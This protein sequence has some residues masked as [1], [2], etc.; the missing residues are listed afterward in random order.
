[1]EII[2]TL[3]YL[4]E[5]CKFEINS[6]AKPRSPKLLGSCALPGFFTSGLCL[7]ETLAFVGCMGAGLAVVNIANPSNPTVIDSYPAWRT[8]GIAIKDTMAYLATDSLRVVNVADPRAAHQICCFPGLAY[9]ADVAVNGSRAYTSSDPDGRF[10]VFDISNPAHPTEVGYHDAPGR[11]VKIRQ[12]GAFVYAACSG[13]G[14]CIFDTLVSVGI[15]AARGSPA[16]PCR[17]RV[18]PNPVHNFGSIVLPQGTQ[19]PSQVS[20]WAVSGRLLA[21]AA[22]NPSN[23]GVKRWPI[24]FTPFPPGVYVVTMQTK[25]GQMTAK[26]VKR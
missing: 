8:W 21:R 25:A 9:P 23:Q 6:I 17:L 11:V 20:I 16:F 2:D 22:I 10:Y 26:V 18:M 7:K 3:L 19:S 13:G 4:A 24:D 15:P 14:L 1:M 12:E 5:D